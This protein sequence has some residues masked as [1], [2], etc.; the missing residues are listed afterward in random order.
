MG[1]VG[2][3]LGQLKSSGVG[4]EGGGYGRGGSELG[5]TKST[6]RWGM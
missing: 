2:L 5:S 1:G 3:N 4:L 6:E